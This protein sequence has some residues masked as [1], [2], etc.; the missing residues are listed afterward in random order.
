MFG[1]L[2]CES[3]FDHPHNNPMNGS[4]AGAVKS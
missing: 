4:V 2:E 3:H 1:V